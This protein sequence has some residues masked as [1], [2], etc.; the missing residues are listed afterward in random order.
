MENG[1]ADVKSAKQPK[2]RQAMSGRARARWALE[3]SWLNKPCRIIQMHAQ[4]WNTLHCS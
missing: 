4:V 1:T 2:N 3:S